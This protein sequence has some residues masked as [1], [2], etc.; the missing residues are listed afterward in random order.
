M[1]RR[2]TVRAMIHRPPAAETW[3]LL[4][5]ATRDHPAPVAAVRWSA[6]EHNLDTLVAAAG[7]VPVRGR[8]STTV[9]RE[10]QTIVGRTTGHRVHPARRMIE[11]WARDRREAADAGGRAVVRHGLPGLDRTP[12]VGEQMNLMPVLGG[13]GDGP[14]DVAAQLVEGVAVA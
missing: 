11:T 10:E 9:L 8:V 13:C 2:S 14:I 1:A 3:E 5:R 7:P 12:V 6:V 4:D